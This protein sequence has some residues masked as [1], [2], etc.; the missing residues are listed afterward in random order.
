MPGMA[1]TSGTENRASFSGEA[2]GTG[3]GPI[4]SFS[5]NGQR[6]GALDITSDGAH[7]IDPGCNCGQA[8]DVNVDMTQEMKVLTSNFGADAAKG[9]ILISAVGKSGTSAFHGQ[10]YLYAR[11]NS[12]DANDWLNNAQGTNPATGQ[13]IAPRPETRYMF[14]GGNIGGPVLIPGTKFNKNRDKLFF[15]VAYEYYNQIVDNGL[16]QA[17][18]ADAGDAKWR[19][20]RRD[21]VP[22]QNGHWFQ[23][24]GPAEVPQRD[25]ACR[26]DRSDRP[27]ANEPVPAAERRSAD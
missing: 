7:I 25:R 13:A 3:S 24:L 2:H 15:F 8:V 14:P 16:Y 18:V 5:A 26:P 19:F 23:H 1:I 27:E 4:G 12:M 10:A 17:F 11:H 20:L 6:T 21:A 22:G 9:P